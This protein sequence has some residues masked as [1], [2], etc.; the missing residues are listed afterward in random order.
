MSEDDRKDQKLTGWLEVHFSSGNNEIF[1]FDV[2]ANNLKGDDIT[3]DKY[4]DGGSAPGGWVFSGTLDG[5]AHVVCIADDELSWWEIT[6]DEEEP[7]KL[8]DSEERGSTE[9][10]TH[11]DIEAP[12][13]YGYTGEAREPSDEDKGV[14]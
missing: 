8:E 12:T 13:L 1:E 11:D 2:D 7:E 3:F 14:R 5:R 4:H 10:L 9:N 6:V